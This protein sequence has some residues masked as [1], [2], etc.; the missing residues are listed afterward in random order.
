MNRFW[1]LLRAEFKAWRKE[2]ITALGGFI[3]PV[4][5]LIAFWLLFGGKLSFRVGFINHDK[6]Q[7]GSILRDTAA[8]VESPFGSPYY[9]LFHGNED[10]IW[11]AYQTYQIEGVWVIPADFSERIEA[12]NNPSFDMY[13]HNYIDDRAKN[14]RL[15][16]AEILW[17]FYQEIKYPPPP[18]FFQESYPRSE[19]IEW[20][21]IIAVGVIL[22]GFM[23]GGM[24]NIFM[25]THKEQITGVIL[26][27]SLAPRSL[28]WVLIPK[29]LLALAAGLVTGTALLGLTSIWLNIWPGK[30]FFAIWLLAGLVCLFWI[31]LVLLAGFRKI[32]FFAG[33]ILTI[34]TGLTVFF[35]GG[36][37]ALVRPFKYRVPWFSWVTPNIYAVDPMRDMILFHQ[38]PADW[39]STLSILVIYATGSIL[40]CGYLASRQLRR[41]G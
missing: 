4:F 20:L 25:L 19:M 33:A 17:N 34:L 27:F 13:F 24:M 35:I 5:I 12:V 28:L 7:F 29:I 1:I 6:G 10:E 23:L 38:W 21:P 16:A 41:L 36:G 8:S 14:H 15:Y 26:E 30:F 18:L 22:L 39:K 3:P 40:V 31:P 2:P 32:N 9:E 37:L 11:E